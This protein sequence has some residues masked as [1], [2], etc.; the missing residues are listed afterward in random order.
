[1][2]DPADFVPSGPGA[3]QVATPEQISEMKQLMERGFKEGA[4][5]AGMVVYGFD[6]HGDGG[7]L[8]AAGAKGV[9]RALDELFEVLTW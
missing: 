1:M 4:V 5:A 6:R 7:H 9:L 3:H 2:H 8:R